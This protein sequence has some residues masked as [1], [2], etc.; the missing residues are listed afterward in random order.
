MVSQR[1]A[2]SFEGKSYP[3]GSEICDRGICKLCSDGKFEIPPELS[4]N[5]EDEIVDPGEAYFNHVL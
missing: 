4:F 5:E 1:G 3:Q 2:C